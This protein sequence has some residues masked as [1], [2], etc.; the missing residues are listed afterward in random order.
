M[1]TEKNAQ[2]KSWELCIIWGLKPR[3][4]YLWTIYRLNHPWTTNKFLVSHLGFCYGATK[5]MNSIW[6]HSTMNILTFHGRR[7]IPPAH[8]QIALVILFL[9]F[10]QGWILLTYCGIHLFELSTSLFLLLYDLF[11]ASVCPQIFATSKAPEYS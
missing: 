11:L 8:H 1:L 2:P 5:Y 3:T 9:I 10:M 6:F 7:C 4:Q